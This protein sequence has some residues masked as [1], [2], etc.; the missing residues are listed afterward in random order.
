MVLDVV[1]RPIFDAV[2]L[3]IWSG[4][5]QAD[6]EKHFNSWKLF[7]AHLGPL[8]MLDSL[9]DVCK[10]AIHWVWTRDEVDQDTSR[11]RVLFMAVL[12]GTF[13]ALVLLA[14]GVLLRLGRPTVAIGFWYFGIPFSAFVGAVAISWE[15]LRL[16]YDRRSTGAGR[17]SKPERDLA[18]D[19]ALSRD[20]KIGF[21]V[22]FIGL[23]ALLVGLQLTRLLVTGLT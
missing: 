17:R 11:D 7:T 19:L 23:A 14:G 3:A 18:P 21:V 12:Y 2:S 13:F 10:R 16:R 9:L 8:P 22:T 6:R 20:T 15:A 1:R 5:H 4:V